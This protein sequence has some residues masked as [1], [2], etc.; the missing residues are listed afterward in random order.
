MSNHEPITQITKPQ[1]KQSRG[2]RPKS[3]HETN[4]AANTPITKNTKPQVK[5]SRSNHATGAAEAITQPPAPLR[6]QGA[7][8][9]T[10]PTDT[11]REKEDTNDRPHST[12][13]P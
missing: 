2:L 7:C 10:R 12:D 6:G 1:V 4:H 3:N 5:Q 11:T 9:T 13:G 8:A